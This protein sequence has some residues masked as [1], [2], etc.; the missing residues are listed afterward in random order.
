MRTSA[1]TYYKTASRRSGVRG[2][3]RGAPRA[4]AVALLALPLLLAACASVRTAAAPD[5]APQQ[6]LLPPVEEP[7]G[8]ERPV[9]SFAESKGGQRESLA[10]WYGPEFHGRPTS[11][12]ERFN[13]HALTCA[14]R[15]LPFGTKLRVVNKRNSKEVECVVNDRGP[16]I[17][18]RELDLSYAAA[19]KIDL[20]GPGVQTVLIE[21]LGRDLRYARQVRYG[22]LEGALTLQ[23]GSFREEGNAKRLKAALELKYKGVYIIRAN[24]GGAPYFRVRMG[25]FTS[26][27]DALALGT[28]LA[29]EGY[30][31]LMTKF[32]QQI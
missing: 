21:P 12:G 30:D 22:V 13:M 16:F 17:A 1:G 25:R 29:D 9:I 19:K 14:H 3:G 31:I 8:R 32:E 4:A 23:V 15:E 18:G 2:P 24:V 20:I 5:P 27:D 28:A 26:K 6:T 10:S 7:Q 11:S